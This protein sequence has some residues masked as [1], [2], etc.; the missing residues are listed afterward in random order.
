[1]RI[2]AQEKTGNSSGIDFFFIKRRKP[3][4]SKS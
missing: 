2:K 3:E 1:M 4:N